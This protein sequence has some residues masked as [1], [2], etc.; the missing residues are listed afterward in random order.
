MTVT[1]K[2]TWTPPSE[3]PPVERR[4]YALRDL[5]VRAAN[6]ETGD[7]PVAGYAAVFNSRSVVMWDWWEGSFV[8]EVEPGAFA[9]TIN[10]GDI[11]FLI[12][13][14]PNLILARKSS[15][16]ETLRLSEDDVGLRVEADM[17]PT[18]YAQDLAISM[19]RGD[20]TQMSFGFRVLRDTWAET[21]D[22]LPLRRLQEVHLFDVSAVTFPA[23]EETEVSARDAQLSALLRTL[24]LGQVPA[25]E[26]DAFLTELAQNQMTPE[27][28]PLLRL[29]RSALE[30]V[31]TAADPLATHSA[32]DLRARRHRS[33]AA[34]DGLPLERTTVE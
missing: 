7:I 1:T 31:A 32:M 16:S 15:R 14:D 11:R 12:N 29:A 17:G 34:R 4:V 25:E 21:E 22:G 28:L 3:R 13:H 23:Y 26:R 33:L 9:R 6:S 27:R 24:G 18:S 30:A 2:R 8:E 20:V 5:E 10:N 19:R